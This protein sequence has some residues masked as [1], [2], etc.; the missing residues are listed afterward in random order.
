M[1]INC[2]LRTL[3]E[4]EDSMV[5]LAEAVEV[6]PDETVGALLDRLTGATTS[7]WVGDKIHGHSEPTRIHDRSACIELR[8]SREKPAATEGRGDDSE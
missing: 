7:R 6:D 5:P 1:K 2:L 3:V 4:Y 8:V